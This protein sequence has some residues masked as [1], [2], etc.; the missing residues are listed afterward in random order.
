M[1]YH[2]GVKMDISEVAELLG[3][4]RFVPKPQHI[5]VISEP[6]RAEVDG[7]IYYRG[8]QPS[9]RSDVIILTPQAVDETVLHEIG[10]SLGLGEIGATLFGKLMIRKS[11]F[12][13]NFPA[14]K[15]LFSHP[16]SYVKCQGCQEFHILHTKYAG[17]AEHYIKG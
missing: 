12:I 15:E 2:Y 9:S 6:V 1:Q 16:V 14:L 4:Y 3:L 17:R 11:R 10:H 7:Y 5:I 13:E 8:I